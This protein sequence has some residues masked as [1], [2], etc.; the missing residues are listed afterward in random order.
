MR[1]VVRPVKRALR[2]TSV[3]AVVASR[4]SGGPMLVPNSRSFV[5][6]RL[7]SS[8]GYGAGSVHWRQFRQASQAAVAGQPYPG[9]DLA[10]ALRDLVFTPDSDDVE[11]DERVRR[12]DY[13]KREHSG[14]RL[15]GGAGTA[16][17]VI[18]LAA[19]I[20]APTAKTLTRSEPSGSPGDARN[21]SC[22]S[23]GIQTCCW[24]D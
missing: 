11:G 15:L 23:G 22:G 8:Q 3:V 4:R 6:R 10:A 2:T 5:D 13:G 24:S 21:P 12:R 16:A 18:G 20:T 14:R 19:V 7:S 1:V 9:H 17:P